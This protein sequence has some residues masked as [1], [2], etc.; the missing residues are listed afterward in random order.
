MNKENTTFTLKSVFILFKNLV[1]NSTLHVCINK[2]INKLKLVVKITCN[3]FDILI[4]FHLKYVYNF[5]TL[6]TLKKILE[7]EVFNKTI[8]GLNGISL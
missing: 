6:K 2:H 7:F 4:V 3:F 1:I 5:S 8:L